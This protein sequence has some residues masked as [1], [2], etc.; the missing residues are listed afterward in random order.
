MKQPHKVMSSSKSVEWYTPKWLFKLLNDKF[1]FTLDAA[2]SDTN[3]LVAKHFTIEDNALV[4][5]WSK[6]IVFI[7]PPFSVNPKFFEKISSCGA[8]TVVVLVPVRAGTKYWFKFVYP[9]ASEILVFKGR[10]KYENSTST[11]PF[12]SCLILFGQGSLRFIEEHGLVIDLKE[13]VSTKHRKEYK[14]LL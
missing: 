6:D 2:S 3:C 11:P 10:L 13:A 9:Y 14:I 12:D 7:N 1:K 8:K 5:D 4:Q